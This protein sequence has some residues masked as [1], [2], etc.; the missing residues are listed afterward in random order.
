M[1]WDRFTA[2]EVS[3]M[4]GQYEQFLSH[5]QKKYKMTREQA[6]REMKTWQENRPKKESSA[7]GRSPIGGEET[8]A[9]LDTHAELAHEDKDPIYPFQPIE[10]R[11][12][13]TQKKDEGPKKR[14]AG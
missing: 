14:K 3:K 2:Q 11:D 1:K 6:E 10:G 12:S 13:K 5:F 8:L 4:N 9:E 7:K